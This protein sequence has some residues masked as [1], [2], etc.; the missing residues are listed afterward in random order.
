LDIAE[1]Q[2]KAETMQAAIE[3]TAKVDIAEAEAGAQRIASAFAAASSSVDSTSKAASDMYGSLAANIGDMETGDK[4]HMED[5]FDD[6]MEMEQQALDMQKD[7]TAAQVEYMEAKTKTMEN[8]DGQ[9][10]ID[11]TGLS[12]ALEMVMWEIL[13]LVQVK[14]TGEQA[15]F[16]LGLGV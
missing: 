13:E 14:A 7:L 10:K 8:G 11:G 16:L 4:W 12:P 15:D 5:R 2:A 9:I 3:W 1:A 6:Q